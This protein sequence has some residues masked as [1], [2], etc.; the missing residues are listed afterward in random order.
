MNIPV[1]H[2]VAD[3][4]FSDL[5]AH[6]QSQGNASP[7]HRLSNLTGKLYSPIYVHVVQ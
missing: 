3:C 5:F 1:Q 6:V 7:T 4:I 2:M